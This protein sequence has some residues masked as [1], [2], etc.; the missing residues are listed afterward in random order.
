M[1]VIP[2]PIGFGGTG[3]AFRLIAVRD[4]A[5]IVNA[6]NLNN[7]LAAL[8]IDQYRKM[9]ELAEKHRAAMAELAE[10]E[11]L[12]YARNLFTQAPTVLGAVPEPDA[13]DGTRFYF[14]KMSPA[15]MIGLAHGQRLATKR[16]NYSLTDLTNNPAFTCPMA[17][18]PCTDLEQAAD[19]QYLF[20][21]STRH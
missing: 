20:G 16:G 11:I 2:P 9:F 3:P 12:E 18:I 19:F 15:F 7:I 13:P 4:H 8:Q 1:I 5:Y 14:L 17:V 21:A 10:D 6:A